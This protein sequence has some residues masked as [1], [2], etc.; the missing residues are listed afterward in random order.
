MNSDP[1]IKNL[2]S[3]ELS[4]EEVVALKIGLSTSLSFN[5]KAVDVKV[6]FEDLYRNLKSVIVLPTE[7]ALIDNFKHKLRR[8]CFRL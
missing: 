4:A 6:S 7:N 8:I 1:V 2:S 3:V 5:P